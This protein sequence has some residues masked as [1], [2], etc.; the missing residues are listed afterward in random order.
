[1]PQRVSARQKENCTDVN[2]LGQDHLRRTID[3]YLVYY[4]RERNHQGLTVTS[5][6]WKRKMVRWKEVF[7][8]GSDLAECS[9]IIIARLR[10]RFQ[11]LDHT[12]S[13]ETPGPF[14]R[15]ARLTVTIVAL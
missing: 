13:V 1:M 11:F 10:E 15:I 6:I 7:V 2:F 3:E 8:G 14:R 12:G 4:H 9:I 5:S